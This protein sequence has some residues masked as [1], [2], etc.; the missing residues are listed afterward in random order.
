MLS[1]M[2]RKL[3][4]EYLKLTGNPTL[5]GNTASRTT[6]SVP[7]TVCHRGTTQQGDLPHLD[8]LV[9][10]YCL[11]ACL[12]SRPPSLC[13]C[14]PTFVTIL[15]CVVAAPFLSDVPV[16]GLVPPVPI[17]TQFKR[18]AFSSYASACNTFSSYAS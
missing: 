8:C 9:G 6:S 14:S 18:I 13:L 1:C 4:K 5:K 16:P 2:L 17:F 12:Q 10:A 15:E 3:L 7:Q 11:Q